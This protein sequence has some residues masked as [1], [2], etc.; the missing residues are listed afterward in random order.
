MN[1]EQLL[2][3]RKIEMRKENMQILRQEI[4]T[5]DVKI[6]IEN[7][8]KRFDYMFSPSEIREQILT[9][10][11][12]ASLFCK[13]PSKQNIAETYG[14]EL[15]KFDKLPSSGKKCI[16]F[17][18]TGEIVHTSSGNTKSADTIYNGAY[19]T[20]KYTDEAGGAQDN[21]KRDVIEFLEKGSKKNKVCAI[22]DGP[23]WEKGREELKK[24]FKNNSNVVAI[25][26]IDEILG[27]K[28]E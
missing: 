15:L 12:T 7:H 16:R 20:M 21:Q 22:L 1:F 27:L 9:N 23:Y 14:L 28:E 18:S 11:L 6:K 13:D 24:L 26:S 17:S 4:D 8:A 5:A 10:D 19:A 25:T 3:K 2:N